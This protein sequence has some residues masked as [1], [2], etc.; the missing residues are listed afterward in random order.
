VPY[1]S[2][3]EPFKLV[4]ETVIAWS[5]DPEWFKSF[6]RSLRHHLSIAFRNFDTNGEQGKTFAE[7]ILEQLKRNQRYGYNFES[8][9]IRKAFWFPTPLTAD[10]EET[11]EEFVQLLETADAQ[12][13]RGPKTTR[14][15]RTPQQSS[16]VILKLTQENW[17]RI[18][19]LIRRVSD[20]NHIDSSALKL[21]VPGDTT[22]S[23]ID[24]LIDNNKALE[25]IIKILD[26][27]PLIKIS[28]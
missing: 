26:T 27:T 10:Q 24:T 19:K 1:L 8:S 20:D 12:Y 28:N 14:T 7:S 17:Q 3:S 11:K 9:E 13:E 5:T 23:T 2:K 16:K 21:E 6:C 18:L 22:L 4:V 15:A 25:D